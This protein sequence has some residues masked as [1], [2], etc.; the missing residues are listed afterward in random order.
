MKK[1]LLSLALLG[2]PAL[3]ADSQSAAGAIN[4]LGI[5]L[6][7]LAAKPEENTALSPFSIQTALVMTYAGAEGD[8]RDQM[9]KVLH[10][11]PDAVADFSA[12]QKDVLAPRKDVTLNV[13]NRLFGQKGFQ[14]VPAYL[15]LV[16]DRFDAPL[17]PLNFAKSEQARVH[18][19]SWVEKQT[20]ERIRDLIPAG[21]ITSATTLV[22]VNAIY[23]KAQWAKPFEKSATAPH[24]FQLASGKAVDV[25]TMTANV[26]VGYKEEKNFR[27]ISIPYSGG[28]LQFVIFLPEKADGL[29]ALEKRLTP[30]LLGESAKLPAEEV[31]LSLPKFKLEPPLF[32]LKDVLVGLGMKSAF[33]IPPGSANFSGIAPRH[34]DDYL[35][36][37]Q[38]FHKAFVE[39]DEQ[40][41]EAAAAT[42]VVMA[43]MSARLSEP[44]EVR[45]DRPFLFAIQHRPSGACL[46]LGRVTDPR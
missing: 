1:I 28:D 34:A 14:F 42:A 23:L 31:R 16:K 46:F 12:F 17:E 27:A 11:P 8:T 41:T 24:P 22:L 45:V 19:N 4:T 36:I 15:A 3:A 25:P 44:R 13:A 21:G 10:L 38:V 26:S 39:V 20:K 5:E 37:S 43:R 9:A 6:L 35:A 30:K 29:A 7:G 40:G 18:I 2:T 33:D 32:S